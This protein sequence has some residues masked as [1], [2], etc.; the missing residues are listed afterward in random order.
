M[1]AIP[2]AAAAL[3]P[4]ILR[5]TVLPETEPA[6]LR[7]AL[8]TVRRRYLCRPCTVPAPVLKAAP[9]VQPGFQAWQ[10]KPHL[11]FRLDAAL[12]IPGFLYGLPAPGGGDHYRTFPTSGAGTPVVYSAD[13]A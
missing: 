9:T 4:R 5:V 12:P 3:R 10:T 11:L 7:F 13:A 6:L 2:Q 1:V 8:H